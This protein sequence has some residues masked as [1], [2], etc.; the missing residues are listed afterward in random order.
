M[1]EFYVIGT[2]ILLVFAYL[3]SLYQAEVNKRLIREEQ[4]RAKQKVDKDNYVF[5]GRR[6]MRLPDGTMISVRVD[7]DY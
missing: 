4:D 3:W 2:S 1:V 7:S 6:H 5:E